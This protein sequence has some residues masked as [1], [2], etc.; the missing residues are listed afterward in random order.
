MIIAQVFDN[1]GGNDGSEPFALA[2]AVLIIAAIANMIAI[3]Y[4]PIM[5]R[6]RIEQQNIED[7]DLL[8]G[9]VIICLNDANEYE[10]FL[11]ELFYVF[12]HSA[13]R[14]VFVLKD[15]AERIDLSNWQ[16][17]NVV[18]GDKQ[19]PGTWRRCAA[20][21]ADVSDVS[22]RWTDLRI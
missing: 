2:A 3:F 8:E 7:L 11:E 13:D 9:H 17:I 4:A 22:T 16:N 21:S 19:D 10:G 15:G 6:I 5:E 12:N 18:S 14:Q 20:N 1:L